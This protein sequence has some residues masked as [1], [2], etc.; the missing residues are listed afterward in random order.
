MIEL[1][2]E[3]IQKQKEK[4]LEEK[5]RLE[6]ELQSIADPD[7]KNPEHYKARFED[8]GDGVDESAI[9][10]YSYEQSLAVEQGLEE[11]LKKVNNALQRIEQGTYGQCE[12]GDEIEKER[13]KVIPW[14]STCIEHSE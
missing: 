3:F 11:M 5:G 1:K 14:A 8:I 7:E 9:E 13:L 6:E 10:V 12:E 2:S 4:L